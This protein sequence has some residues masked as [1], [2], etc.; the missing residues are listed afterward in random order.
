MIN[1]WQRSH[2]EE[3]CK[4]TSSKPYV[5]FLGRVPDSR[6][7]LALGKLSSLL[8]RCFYIYIFLEGLNS[9]L[10]RAYYVCAA[11]P[12]VSPSGQS[13]AFF[14]RAQLNRDGQSLV[15]TGKSKRLKAEA[16]KPSLLSCCA[17]GQG[18]TLFFRFCP[19]WDAGQCLRRDIP[20]SLKWRLGNASAI[21]G[22]TGA[23][24]GQASA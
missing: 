20:R 23:Q 16:R 3:R 7:F 17:C 21:A 14:G 24:L 10:S 1:A 12:T 15:W 8:L 9:N 5:F 18:L 6:G 13:L 4:A 19:R 11:T 2:V 22:G